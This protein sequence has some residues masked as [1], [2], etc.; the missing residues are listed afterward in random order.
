MMKVKELIKALKRMPE[1]AYVFVSNDDERAPL[2]VVGVRSRVI[3]P[4]DITEVHL[5]TLLYDHVL[6]EGDVL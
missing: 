5:V 6:G 1:E 4:L 3:D 2:G